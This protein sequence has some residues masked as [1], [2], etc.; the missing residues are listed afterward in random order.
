M[1]S[2]DD[3]VVETEEGPYMVGGS[4]AFVEDFEAEAVELYVDDDAE[5]A[6]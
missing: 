3:G 1:R 4:G 2:K 6:E 5:T